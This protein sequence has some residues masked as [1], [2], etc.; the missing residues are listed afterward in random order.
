M[1]EQRSPVFC[2]ESILLRVDD[3]IA[4]K[5]CIAFKLIC[6]SFGDGSIGGL[7]ALGS[8][9]AGMVESL[10]KPVTPLIGP[11]TPFKHRCHA[12]FP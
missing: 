11:T 3:S 6:D 7:S 1:V 12:D 2:G 5:G 9:A 8:P 4:A 10:D